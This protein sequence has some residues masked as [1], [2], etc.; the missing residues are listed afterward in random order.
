[1]K[2]K[3]LHMIGNSHIDPVWFWDWDEG[4]QEVRATFAS[5]LDRLRESDEV[6]FTATSAA[7]FEW[8]EAVDPEMFREVQE[9][10]AQGRFELTGGWLIEPDCIL[11]CGEA[12]VRQGLYG[13]RY[14]R[15]KFGVICRTGSNVDSFGHSQM[16]PQILKKSGMEEYVFMRPR[17]ETPLFVWESEDGSRVRAVSLPSEY[18]TWF[19]EPARDAV[20]AAL[21]AAERQ[22]LSA[23]VCCYGVGNHGGGPTKENIRAVRQLDREREEAD[24]IFSTYRAFFDQVFKENGQKIT[25]IRASFD[26]VNTGCYSMD[27]LLK[28]SNRLAENRILQAESMLAMEALFL[29]E[30]EKGLAEKPHRL[31]GNQEKEQSNRRDTLKELWKTLLFNQF[32]DTLGGTAVKPARDEAVAQFDMVCASS[33]R[34]AVFSMQRMLRQIDTRGEGF[35]LVLWNPAGRRYAGTVCAELN[36][37]CKDGLTLRDPEGKEIPYQRIHTLAKARNYNLGGRRGIVFDADI[38]AMG[39]AVYRVFAQDSELCDDSRESGGAWL[40]GEKEYRLENPFLEAVFRD[41]CLSSLIEKETGYDALQGAVS[42]PVWLDERDTWG[43]DQGRAFG[44]SGEKLR[45]ESLQVVEEGSLRNVIRAV[46]RL[47]G[48]VLRQEYILYHDAGWLEVRNLLFWDRPWQMLKMEYPLSARDAF[49]HRQGAYCTAEGRPVDGREY[50]MHRFVDVAA[51]DG[52]GLCLANDGK[53]VFVME[54]NRLSFPVARSAIFAQGNGKNWYNP[55]EGYEYADMGEQ[56]FTFLLR[57]HGKPLTPW[58]RYR[59]GEACAGP[60]LYLADNCH[61]GA[62]R[63][64]A[65]SGLEIDH[66]NVELGCLKLSEDGDGY[67]LRLFETMGREA[68]GSVKLAGHA[69]AYRIHPYEILSIK[70]GRNFTSQTVNLLEDTYEG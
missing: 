35:P 70:I 44:P 48:S 1:M 45:P 55:V 60:V 46:Y 63:T 36:W 10:V 53:Y 41:G 64:T 37:F 69:I 66:E 12:F 27:G 34:Q 52:A 54:G 6:K 8:I 61:G 42:F 7:F 26:G 49:A 21:S 29:G 67:V 30:C 22:G 24:L 25:E 39:F 68:E 65:W 9:R 17:L 11:P 33:K 57:P 56:R 23:M 58:E 28:K 47:G 38:P 31:Q 13:Q 5:A 43:G 19:Y 16:L 2:K 18:T 40:T 20:E 4:M 51:G 32:H 62:V 50:S 59:M 15:E 14:F 3:T